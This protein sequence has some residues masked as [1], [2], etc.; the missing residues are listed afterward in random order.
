M[1]PKFRKL[2]RE[3]FAL[4]LESVK[5]KAPDFDKKL[6]DLRKKLI[7]EME[8]DGS[9]LPEKRVGIQMVAKIIDV[10]LNE[11]MLYF[12]NVVKTGLSEDC[13]IE[14]HLGQVYFRNEA[15]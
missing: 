2:V 5:Q 4:M 13:L 9:S 7:P 6:E 1:A 12:M 10:P 15:E 8:V 11:L 3:E 14:Y